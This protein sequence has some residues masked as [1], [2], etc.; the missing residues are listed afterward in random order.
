MAQDSG[1]PLVLVTSAGLDSLDSPAGVLD[2]FLQIQ[3]ILAALFLSHHCQP[4][5]RCP[6]LSQGPPALQAG[7]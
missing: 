3:M 6:L 1:F 2:S 7:R 4:I 5:L